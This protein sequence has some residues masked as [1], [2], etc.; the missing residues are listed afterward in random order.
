M[1][2]LIIGAGAVGC[3]T[4][5]QLTSHGLDVTI[6]DKDPDAIKVGRVPEADWVL[7]DACSPSQLEEAGAREADAVAALTGD[8][9]VN[10]V[11][12]LLAKTEFAVPQ[13]IARANHT[14]NEWMY[15]EEWGVDVLASTP[16]AITNLVEEAIS[17]GE[18]VQLL[19]LDGSAT[20]V[21]KIQLPHGSAQVGLSPFD[22][23]VHS[24]LILAAVIRSGHPLAVESVPSL[25]AGDELLV[26]APRQAE[27]ELEALEQ[28]VSKMRSER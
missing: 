21:Y 7:A 11:V 20:S 4:A 3:A 18:A 8:D 26:V 27:A 6:I 15:N 17:V 14:A 16:R 5:Q 24:P 2:I 1:K 19:A 12:S 10:L 22:V 28:A 13:V 9:K 25:K 23:P